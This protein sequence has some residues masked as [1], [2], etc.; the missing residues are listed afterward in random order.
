MS[1]STSIPAVCRTARALREAKGWT[2][3]EAAAVAAD[4]EE[5]VSYQAI[6]MLE[7]GRRPNPSMSTLRGLSRIYGVTIDATALRAWLAGSRAEP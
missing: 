3:Q 7:Q 1:D 5:E 2:L 4:F 6:W